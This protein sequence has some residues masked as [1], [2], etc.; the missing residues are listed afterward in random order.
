MTQTFTVR[1]VLLDM[2]GTLV[3]SIAVVERLWLEWAA[4]HDLDPDTVLT[5][6]HGRQGHESMALLLPDR[7]H[8]INIAE[9]QALLA[10]ETADTRGVVEITGARVLLKALQGVPHAIVTSANRPLLEARM[11]AAGLPLTDIIVTAEDVTASKPHPEGF[12]RAAELLGIPAEEC[13]VLEDSGAGIQAAHA[14]GMA[15]IGIGASAAKHSPHA[16]VHDLQ[17]LGVEVNDSAI[18][19]TVTTPAEESCH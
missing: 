15:V 12:L 11:A 17:P 7:D 16:V 13:L 8:A 6:V 18:T 14:A 9:N 19:I 2:D 4:Q 10:A 1:A 3:N 5:T